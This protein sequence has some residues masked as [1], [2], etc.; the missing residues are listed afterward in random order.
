MPLPIIKNA[1]YKKYKDNLTYRLIY[2]VLWT[3]TYKNGWDIWYGSH[4]GVDIASSL[5]TPV[6]AI[7]DWVVEK[8]WYL[9]WWWNTVVIKHKLGNKFIRSVYAHLSKILVKENDIVKKGDIIGY[10][11][12]TGRVTGAHLHYANRLHNVT[13]DPLQFANLYNEIINSYH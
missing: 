11:G 13:V 9:R 4:L 3:A 5:W 6:Y 1:N 2:S 7:W 8:A 12:A 10:S